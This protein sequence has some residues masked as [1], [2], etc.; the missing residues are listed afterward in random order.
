MTN[1]LSRLLS[2]LSSHPSI[3]PHLL[4]SSLLLFLS[5][6]S[7]MFAQGSKANRKSIYWQKGIQARHVSPAVVEL[8]TDDFFLK[9]GKEG[10]LS[11]IRSR[12]R[13]CEQTFPVCINSLKKHPFDGRRYGFY[14]KEQKHLMSTLENMFRL[15]IYPSFLSFFELSCILLFFELSGINVY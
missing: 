15:K 9:N 8:K 5:V 12:Y 4:Y 1:T 7:L 14:F 10:E 13:G 6:K 3:P 2:K 11:W